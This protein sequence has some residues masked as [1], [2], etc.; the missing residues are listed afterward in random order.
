M[1]GSFTWEKH[2][3][4][5]CGKIYAGLR[6]LWQSALFMTEEIRQRLVMALLMPHILYCS[7]VLGD[8]HENVFYK[9]QKAYNSCLRFIFRVPRWARMTPYSIKFLGCPL[10]EFLKFR[11]CLTIHRLLLTQTPMYLSDKL[12]LGRSERLGHIML[13]RNRSAVKNNSFLVYGSSLYNRLPRDL[14]NLS[15]N[16]FKKYCHQYFCS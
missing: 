7:S 11:T 4:Y 15:L 16:Q 10:R 13:P 2:I 12:C 1:D 6:N 14:K 8:L 3:V 9:L 5:T